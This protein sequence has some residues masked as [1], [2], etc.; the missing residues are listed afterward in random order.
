MTPGG[1]QIYTYLKQMK[2][3]MSANVLLVHAVLD[4]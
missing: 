3:N 4:N 1:Y 2:K